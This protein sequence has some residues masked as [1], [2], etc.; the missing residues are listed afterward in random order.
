MAPELLLSRANSAKSPIFV[1]ASEDFSPLAMPYPERIMTGRKRCI[2]ID[3][4]QRLQQSHNYRY[5]KILYQNAIDASYDVVFLFNRNDKSEFHNLD[6]KIVRCFTHS[7]YDYMEIRSLY[8]NL[9][10]AR[11]GRLVSSLWNRIGEINPPDMIKRFPDVALVVNLI[12][13]AFIVLIFPLIYIIYKLYNYIIYKKRPYLD[14][15]FARELAPQLK[16]LKITANDIVI[17]HSGNYAMIEALFLLRP[18]LNMKEP[19]PAPL[20]VVF[21]HSM[22]ESHGES[23]NLDYYQRAE[24]KWLRRRCETGLPFRELHLYGTNEALCEEM[25][26]LSGMEFK[27]FNH[28]EE[29]DKFGTHLAG[30]PVAEETTK[31]RILRIGVR[32]KDVNGENGRAISDAFSAIRKGGSNVTFVLLGKQPAPTADLQRFMASVPGIDVVS[33]DSDN[34]YLAQLANLDLLVQPYRQEDYA[35][36]IS[37]VFVECALLGIPTVSPDKT[38]I[39]RSADIAQVF[40]YPQLPDLAAAIDRFLKARLKPSF[41]EERLNKMQAARAFYLRNCIT[42][43]FAPATKPV[44]V[45]TAFGPIAVVVSPFWGKCGSSTVFDSNTEYLLTRGYFVFRMMISINR[46]NI[47]NLGNIYQFFQENGMRVRPHGFLL[48]SRTRMS[49]LKALLYPSFWTQSAFGQI[50]RLNGGS[51]DHDKPL[52]AYV[53]ANAEV[54]VVNHSY[55]FD[56]ARQFRKARIIL[57]TQDIQSHQLVGH[58]QKNLVTQRVESEAQFL[59]DEIKVWRSV[60]A[61]VN[62]SPSENAVIG[63][64]CPNSFYIRP[65]IDERKVVLTRNW[66]E[67]VRANHLDNSFLD[68]ESI[69]MI[70]WGD[71]HPMNVQSTLWFLREIVQPHPVLSQKSILIV[72]RLGNAIFSHMGSQP[73]WYY[74]SFLDKL[75]DCFLKSK[76]LVLPDQIGT[77]MSIKT[78]ETLAL[79][80]PFVAT[81]VAMRG[82]DPGDTQF[83][84]TT[85]GPELQQDIVT[86]LGSPQKRRQRAEAARQLFNLNFAPEQYYRK[87]DEVMQSVG[88]APL[89]H[90]K[91]TT[92]KRESK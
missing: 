3:P 8:R 25:T 10:V 37:A 84:S 32:A 18:H 90:P 75:D 42:C 16:R 40:A 69:D 70:V 45:I 57:E 51:L 39:S 24:L 58:R 38:T 92:S 28:V 11:F 63:Q 14:D 88:L 4:N 13:R 7:T 19:F 82:V 6:A 66:P 20:H 85:N 65:Y 9:N 79:G 56:Y 36:R 47:N 26:E 52:A 61:T 74:S 64:H 41:S 76:L 60:D 48:A 33:T 49:T 54:A 86:L 78:L 30:I 80:L 50:N 27:L 68:I 71:S 77:G 67:F 72:G 91:N 34:D 15:I 5:N 59:V 29:T 55:H 21:H 62:L 12:Y 89:S 44:A 17:V 2:V 31:N 43:D 46:V 23:F 87:W 81:D 73:R 22:T 1:R 35:K 53:F 83:R